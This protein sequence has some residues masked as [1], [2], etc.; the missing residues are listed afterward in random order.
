[1]QMEASGKDV[2]PFVEFWDEYGVPEIDVLIAGF[3][4]LCG[5]HDQNARLVELFS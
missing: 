4:G 2:P 1:M 3:D 5:A